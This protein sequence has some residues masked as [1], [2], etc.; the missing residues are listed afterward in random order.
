MAEVALFSHL[1]N[2]LESQRSGAEP[3]KALFTHVSLYEPRTFVITL[4]VLIEIRHLKSF[5]FSIVSILK[6]RFDGHLFRT[7]PQMSQTGLNDVPGYKGSV[8]FCVSYLQCTT[9]SHAAQ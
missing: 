2:N 6:E 3:G 7:I 4:H 5:A 9:L 8:Q 1:K